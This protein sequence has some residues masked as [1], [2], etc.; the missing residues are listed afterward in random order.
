MRNKK[1]NGLKAKIRSHIY[2]IS[3]ISIAFVAISAC[4]ITSF[5]SQR[6]TNRMAIAQLDECS[7]KLQSW[8]E[9]KITLTQFIAEE[10][11]DRG[12]A[13]DKSKC[14][15]F[16]VDCIER[17][18]ESYDVYL[19]YADGSAVF[20]DGWEPAPGEYDPTTRDW[21]K[22]AIAADGIVIADPY[23]DA[24]SGRQVITCAVK[25]KID[26]EVIG[27]LAR[28]IFIDEIG[29]IVYSLHIDENGYA[30]LTKE[31]G[32]IIIHKNN[33]FM[34]Y[35]D[36]DENTVS[37]N[38]SD[39]MEGYSVT[40]GNGNVTTLK[41]HNGE[42]I[43]FAQTGMTLVNWKLG[44][45]MNYM[46]YNSGMF[47]MIVIFAAM[48]VIFSSIIAAYVSVLLKRAFDP[49]SE[50][51]DTAKTVAQGHLDVFFD[52]EGN[53]EISGV[54]RTIE[55]NNR[56]MKDYIEDISERLSDISHGQFNNDSSVEYL[57][58]YAVIKQSL[59]DISNSLGQ[60]FEGIE[61][62]S[63]AVYGGAEGVADSAN[64]L[65]ESVS[66]Q[67]AVINDIV[68]EMKTVSEK[69]TGNVASTDNARSIAKDTADAV[70]KSNEQMNNLL[71][72][73]KEISSASEEI[74]N[75]IGTIED[76]AFQTNILAL[77]ASVE[78][79]RAGSAGRGF[80]VVADEVRNL[81]GKSSEASVQTSELIE[82][83]AKAVSRGL[84][85]A[86]EASAALKKVVEHT[87]E[88]DG[89]IDRINEESH[90]QNSC[91]EDVNEK[92]NIIAE[93]VSSAAANAEES[94]AASEELN[95]Q[96]SA[97]KEMLT[98]FGTSSASD[99][100]ETDTDD[101]EQ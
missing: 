11:V 83:S 37:T 91:I 4:V 99:D 78:A 14:Q 101:I 77:N 21:Y 84:K 53:D 82:H 61:N 29:K 6:Q 40:L 67:T 93:Y 42:K 13:L 50:V 24:Q 96:A 94:A 9:E 79:A 59:D 26:D 28:D 80:A 3:M 36:A 33:D 27:V 92:I 73:M 49:L 63:E 64:Q 100:E 44:Y 85:Y 75:I 76:I 35:A 56:V 89:I 48:T 54:C 18:P 39:V 69:V 43:K 12:Y 81:A 17:D 25:I 41:D 45:A 87:N 51:S 31:D 72:A 74:K 97:L 90:D 47:Y 2:L 10:I 32:S 52:Y 15:P 60:V 19:G 46:E 20:G 66:M 22:A 30:V 23:T 68:S 65:A 70:R 16:L 34:P 5:V 1:N 8:L 71:E 88:I 7:S 95:G 62:A 86:E 57:G 58:D 38:L 98:N 55:A